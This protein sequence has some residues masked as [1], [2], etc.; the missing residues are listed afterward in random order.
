MFTNSGYGLDAPTQPQTGFFRFIK[1]LSEIDWRNTFLYI[2]FDYDG[3]P[4]S[5]DIRTKFNAEFAKNRNNFPSLCL[6]TSIDESKL[7]S[8]WTKKAPTVEIIA[9]VVTLARH[10]YELIDSRMTKTIVKCSPAIN[11]AQFFCPSLSG[12]NAVI[13]VRKCHVHT[14]HLYDFKHNLKRKQLIDKSVPAAEFE[15]I[16][17]YVRDL[18]VSV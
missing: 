2:S 6:A 3:E 18:R 4:E 9:R 10:S 5:D 1:L 13:V 17:Y 14:C 11:P 15:P 16:E 8:I 12:Y 7:T